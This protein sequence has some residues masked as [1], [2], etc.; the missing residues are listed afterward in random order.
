MFDIWRPQD[1]DS[2]SSFTSKFQRVSWPTI[3]KKNIY[4]NIR[5]YLKYLRYL[6]N[7]RRPRETVWVHKPWNFKRLVG[8]ISILRYLKENLKCLQI[9]DIWRPHE[10]V[11]VH[12][13]WICNVQVG[14]E[15]LQ[16][17]EFENI[18]SDFEFNG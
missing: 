9:F 15:S 5:N 6:F 16:T 18:I 7:I 11:W 3:Q 10:T 1:W 13:P 2:L 14:L 17:V 12:Q 8:I 4:K